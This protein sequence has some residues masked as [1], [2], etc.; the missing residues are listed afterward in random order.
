MTMRA[1]L[2]GFLAGLALLAP[3]AAVAQEVFD[4]VME[5]SLTLRLGSSITGIVASVEV[6]RGTPVVKDQVLARLESSVEIA[7]LA[8]ARARAESNAEMDARRARLEQMRS[9]VTRAASLHERSVVSTQRLEELRANMAI[10]AS[11]MALADLN[12]R[13]AALEVGRVEAMLEQRVI[14]SPVN[15][16]VTGRNLGPGEY[17]HYDN[18]VVSVAQLD[19][20]HVETFLPVRL[21]GRVHVGSVATVRPEPPVGGA[22]TAQI[23]V[24]DDVFDA[25]SGTFGVR[26]TLPNPTRALPGGVRCRVE[27]EMTPGLPQAPQARR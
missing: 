1:G 15:G 11:D 21:H 2:C 14:R 23:R 7:T 6:D 5:P 13:V 24:L 12:R 17:I 3:G 9:E 26:L 16:V 19:P 10:A 27:F 22:Y 25:A 8:L 20:L 4:C 18:H